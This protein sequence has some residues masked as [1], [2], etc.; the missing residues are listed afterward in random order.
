M[1][2]IAGVSYHRFRIAK[3]LRSD[4][5]GATMKKRSRPASKKTG[6]KKR[7]PIMRHSREGVKSL[8]RK[9]GTK[10]KRKAASKPRRGVKKAARKVKPAKAKAASAKWPSRSVR[11]PRGER[12]LSLESLSDARAME[13]ESGIQSGDME[14]L[15]RLEDADSESVEEL[16]EEGQ[17][18]EAGVVSGV[19]E[20]D[21]RPGGVRTRQVPVDDVPEE[22]L[23]E[24]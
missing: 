13:Y 23:D 14:G 7:K 5:G 22:Y 4:A 17:A 20:A 1:T 16:L 3:A 12:E 6:K 21:A 15:S 24:D 2:L 8:K 9:R 11:R 18:F 10:T 19:E